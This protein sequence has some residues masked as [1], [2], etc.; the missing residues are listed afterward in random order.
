MHK[1]AN[2][3]S[4]SAFAPPAAAPAG[5]AAPVLPGASTPLESLR[6]RWQAAAEQFC[7]AR[8]LP[9]SLLGVG[10]SELRDDATEVPPGVHKYKQVGCLH[11]S[12]IA[13]ISAGL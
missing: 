11:Q 10:V 8:G 5:Y 7:T 2:N 1:A 6:G 3:S 9:P 4:P 13:R 12:D